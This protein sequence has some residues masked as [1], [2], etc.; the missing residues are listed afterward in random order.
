DMES[1]CEDGALLDLAAFNAPA[2]GFV[3]ARDLPALQARF[4]QAFASHSAADMETRLNAVG[5][6]AARVRRLGEFMGEAQAAGALS[7]V[8][9]QQAGTGVHTPGLGFRFA[10]AP[11]V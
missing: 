5:V 4:R 10:A 1:L 11:S 2:G 6:P 3:V 8:S 9:Y 7:P